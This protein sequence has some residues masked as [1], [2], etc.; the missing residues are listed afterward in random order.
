MLKSR[1]LLREPDGASLS[2]VAKAALEKSDTSP[3]V[4]PS[5]IP[6]SVVMRGGLA[7]A[8]SLLAFAGALAGCGNGG[9]GDTPADAGSPGGPG[10]GACTNVGPDSTSGVGNVVPCSSQRAVGKVFSQ[11]SANCGVGYVTPDGSSSLNIVQINGQTVCVEQGPVS[12]YEQA[13]QGG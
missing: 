5:D 13:Q 6:R 9:G 10:I 8:F 4:A 2:R 3:R 7:G 1:G 11:G 12:P